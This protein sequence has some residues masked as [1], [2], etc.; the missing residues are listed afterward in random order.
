MFEQIIKDHKYILTEGSMYDRLLRMAGEYFDP[1]LG[2]LGLIF[3]DRG[4]EVLKKVYSEYIEVA[5]KYNLPIM[6]YTPTWKANQERIAQSKYAKLDVNGLAAAFLLEIKKEYKGKGVT[7]LV[8]GLFGCKGDCYQ[9]GVSLNFKQS[10]EFHAPQIEKLTESGVDYI[11]ASTLPASLEAKGMA[12]VASDLN[13]ALVLSFVVDRE[14][15][16]LDGRA[17]LEVVVEIDSAV[18]KKPL[19]YMVNCVHP[20]VFANGYRKQFKRNQKL[21]KR[22]LGIQGNT[23]KKASFE[24]EALKELETQTPLDFAKDTINLTKE[25]GLKVLGGCCGTSTEHIEAI[26]VGLKNDQSL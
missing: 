16:I 11:F 13:A 9:P 4:R 2:H 1:E 23:S 20:T 26:A 15:S 24:L 17:L 5:A 25:F 22:V 18:S 10:I 3:T 14:G 8:G 12:Q 6:V 7:V 21:G 19:F